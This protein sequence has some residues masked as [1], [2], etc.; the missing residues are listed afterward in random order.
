[1]ISC[2]IRG[3]NFHP[4]DVESCP[5]SNCHLDDLCSACYEKHKEDCL[6]EGG[7]I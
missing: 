3:R 7:Y 5:N 2:E 4:D 1:M 6:L